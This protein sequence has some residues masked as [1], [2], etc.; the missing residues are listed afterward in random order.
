[1]FL[2]LAL[3]DLNTLQYSVYHDTLYMLL[4]IFVS[5]IGNKKRVINAQR[6]DMIDVVIDL[7][8]FL[9]IISEIRSSSISFFVLLFQ[10]QAA[11]VQEGSMY[12]CVFAYSIS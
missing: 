2:S 6:W 1:M 10:A 8:R 11:E 4:F 3:V 12:P 5:K 9:T 7:M